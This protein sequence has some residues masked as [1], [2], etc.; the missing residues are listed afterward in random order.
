MIGCVRKM[1]NGLS[2]LTLGL[3]LKNE[4]TF[5]NFYLGSNTEV[6]KELKRTVLG[7]GERMIYLCG[8]RGQGLSH[9]LQAACHFAH[10]HQ[11]TSV[12]L[13]LADLLALS[14]E[15]LQGFDRHAV[16]CLD[17]LHVI[18]GL[19]EWEEALFH[20]YNR[21]YDVGG[22]LM[23]AGHDL[24]KSI[25]FLLPDLVSRLSA[26]MVYQLRSLS[27]EEKLFML[28]ARADQ[29][30]IFLSEEVGKYILTHC[31]RHARTLL[32][33]LDVL[34]KASLAAKRRLTIPFI[35]EVLQI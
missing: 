9:L 1:E 20:F 4:A 26:A 21:V 17:D 29:R 19:P 24:P 34:D 15:V 35:K 16:I 18:A 11:F 13:P 27:D 33:A 23:M 8:A 22:R 5:E 3:S 10:Q 12:Y 28:I 14:P 31:P 30:G 32:A 2:Q 6:L 25:S 7:E